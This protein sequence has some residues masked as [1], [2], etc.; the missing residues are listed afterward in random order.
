VVFAAGGV[1]A[2][3]LAGPFA[4]HFTYNNQTT[5]G[6]LVKGPGG[7]YVSLATVNHLLNTTSTTN[8]GTKTTT[9]AADTSSPPSSTNGYPLSLHITPLTQTAGTSLSNAVTANW[10]A[11][12]YAG[13]DAQLWL[14]GKPTELNNEAL[15]I[16][17]VGGPSKSTVG[18]WTLGYYYTNGGTVW[19]NAWLS[20]STSG[21]T[22]AG[23]FWYQ[24]PGWVFDVSKRTT[25][26]LRMVVNQPG[27]YTV[28]FSDADNSHVAPVTAKVNFTLN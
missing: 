13:F 24:I 4:W 1:S 17:I 12:H 2:A 20:P 7:P 22:K 21:T 27:T 25:V 23:G 8:P 10:V 15:K 16:T 3:T 19:Q 14:N 6:T 9:F 26:P 18:L 5:D 11:G 28:T